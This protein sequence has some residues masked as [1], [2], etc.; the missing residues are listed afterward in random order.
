MAPFTA[1]VFGQEPERVGHLYF[2]KTFRGTDQLPQIVTV[3]GERPGVEFA[4]SAKTSAGGDWLSISPGPECCIT[5]APL[6]VSV[7]PD[8]A[9]APGNYSGQ[10]VLAGSAG[11]QVIDVDLIV[12][13]PQVPAFDRTPS[14]LSFSMPAGGDVP[15]QMMQIGSVGEGSLAWTVIP[16]ADFLQ[17]SV[18]SGTAP[19]RISVGIIRDKLPGEGR[20]SGV[21]TGQLLFVSAGSTTTIPVTVAVGETDLRL[22]HRL[23]AMKAAGVLTSS[24]AAGPTNLW[25]AN[26][27]NCFCGSFNAQDTLYGGNTLAPDGTNSAKQVG[28]YNPGGAVPHYELRYQ[29]LGSGPRTISFHLKADTDTWAYLTSQVDGVVRRI[30]FNLSTGT[31]GNNTIP[32]G[33]VV[34]TPVSLGNG[35]YRYAVSFTAAA[36][37]GK[38]RFR[39]GNRRPGICLRRVQRTRGI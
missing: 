16:S 20:R 22:P 29:D 19:T 6:M 28:E 39:T 8:V 17:V 30:W 2:T 15:P 10:V 12:T 26:T 9:L 11:P 36:S 33:W 18:D 13:P 3:T 24:P 32:S 1:S 14:Q 25:P 35:W 7:K 27:A 34:H 37:A 5:P 31:P 38:Q 21:Y 23:K 4:A